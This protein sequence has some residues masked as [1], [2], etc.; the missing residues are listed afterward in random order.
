MDIVVYGRSTPRCNYCE[1]A[2]Q[3]LDSKGLHYEYR[4][5]SLEIDHMEHLVNIG[6]RTVPFIYIDK[7]P[8][9]GFSD[10]ERTLAEEGL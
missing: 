2:K 5:V 9:G 1:A 4:D 8:V 6:V 7:R 3:L 10:L